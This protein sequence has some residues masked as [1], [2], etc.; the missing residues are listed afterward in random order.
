MIRLQQQLEFLVEIDKLKT[1]FRRNY[2]ADGSRTEND[3][4]HSWTFAMAALLLHEFVV[5]PIDLL[6]VLKMALIHDIVEVDVGDTFIY[7]E[8]AK[9]GQAEREQRAAERLFGALPADQGADLLALWREFE[10]YGTPEA[11]YARAIDRVS[12]LILNLA[13]SGRAWR[14]H[15]VTCDRVLAIN[16]RIAD[17][18]PALWDHVRALIE[19]AAQNGVFNR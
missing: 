5:E 6:K 8:A 12:A 10:E 1:I 15:G 9:V 11:R 3:A 17:S 4:E 18:A 16:K 7:D 19:N 14:E 2:I 13:S